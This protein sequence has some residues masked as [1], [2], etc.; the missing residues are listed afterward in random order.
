MKSRIRVPC[1]DVGSTPENYLEIIVQAAPDT[2][3]FVDAADFGG[4]TG[5]IR[6]VD[7][8]LDTG[9]GLSTHALSLGMA[10]DY[11]VAR[12]VGRVLLLAIQPQSLNLGD[13]LSPAVDASLDSL[14]A[15]FLE[16]LAIDN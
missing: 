11:L 6:L 15:W 13:P 9:A 5:D 3:L 14:A 2:V 7:P 16:S 8:A 1:L 10:T 4:K 12:G